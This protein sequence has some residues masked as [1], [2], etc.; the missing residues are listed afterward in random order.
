MEDKQFREKGFL[1]TFEAAEMLGVR[2]AT[3]RTWRSLGK[4]PRF[5]KFNR[6]VFY[7]AEDL[8]AWLSEHFKLVEPKN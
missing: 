8:E 4:G 3:V 2:P 5:Y 1:N 7:K 6:A